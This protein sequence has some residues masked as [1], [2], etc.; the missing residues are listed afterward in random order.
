MIH[1]VYIKKA[2]FIGDIITV[3]MFLPGAVVLQRC[4]VC[5]S[6]P[7]QH[8]S[9]LGEYH[10]QMCNHFNQRPV[11]CNDDEVSDRVKCYVSLAMFTSYF[12]VMSS[13]RWANDRI[14]K[15]QEILKS[16]YCCVSSI[17]ILHW[18]S[19]YSTTLLTLFSTALTNIFM[20]E[21][22]QIREG[23]HTLYSE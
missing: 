4:F 18:H 22:R 14:D 17:G 7:W 20:N 15:T 16:E 11:T 10:S 6:E 3:N 2:P 23:E 19:S 9:N 5:D 13:G 21:C 12:R 8:D 1:S